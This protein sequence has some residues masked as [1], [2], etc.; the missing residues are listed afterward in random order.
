MSRELKL[1]ILLTLLTLAGC[2][3]QPV[4]KVVKFTADWCG[5]CRAMEPVLQEYEARYGYR[6]NVVRVNVDDPLTRTPPDMQGIPYLIITKAGLEVF[7]GNI[8]LPELRKL[9]DG[10]LREGN[11]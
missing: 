9:L 4:I 11:K 7:R 6:L 8:S 3:S 1:L 10:L 2:T 5:Y